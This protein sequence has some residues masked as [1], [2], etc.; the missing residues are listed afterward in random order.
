[1]NCNKCGMVLAENDAFCP[2]CG[3][4]VPET[5][6]NSNVSNG[7]TYSE[8][9]NQEVNGANYTPQ[10]NYSPQ[11][12]YVPQN[13]YTPQDSYGQPNNYAP[14]NS[15][16]PQDNYAQQNNYTQPN[17]ASQNNYMPQ[18]N[19]APQNNYAQTNSYIQTDDYGRNNYSQSSE[20]VQTGNYEQPN[21]NVQPKNQPKKPNNGGN[22]GIVKICVILV[23]VV[24]I[25]AVI[26]LV[27]FT[28]LSDKDSSDDK[29]DKKRSSAITNEDSGSGTTNDIDDPEEPEEPVNP[30]SSSYKVNY[31][32][33]RFYI[34]DNLIYQITAQ[35]LNVGDAAGTWAAAIDVQTVSFEQLKQNI[36]S[37]KSSFTQTL[38][39]YN[40]KISDAVLETVDGVEFIV[41]EV[42]MAGTNEL[43]ACT[44]L[45][46]MNAACLEIAN[47][48]N[49]FDRSILKQLAPIFKTAE[50]LDGADGIKLKGKIDANDLEA[51]L[52]EAGE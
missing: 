39:A 26:A 4:P 29:E 49:D 14:Q 9:V 17:Y 32:G 10:N 8:P 45:N 52:K 19:Y 6:N 47:E 35:S 46:S 13:N 27:L 37:L 5:N 33:F 24:A 44:G 15:Y 31:G 50:Y 28:V 18:E 51:I 40:P 30:S 23:I 2:V 21:S 20:N 16:V 3:T 38:S 7:G 41:L 12:N 36:N 22:G 34:P 1:M 42:E 25:V 48:N 43:L 11:N